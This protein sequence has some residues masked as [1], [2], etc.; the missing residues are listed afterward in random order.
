M[1]SKT[2]LLE[3]KIAIPYLYLHNRYKKHY[4]ILEN[5]KSLGVKISLDDYGVG[6]TSLG[7]LKSLP[8]D[9]LK[10]DKCF[11]LQLEQSKQDQY[12]VESTVNLGHQL[13]FSVVAE[14]VENKA[15]L[16]FLKLMKCDYAQGY[17][18][19]RPLKSEQFLQWLEV[20]N[21]AS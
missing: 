2:T 15:S 7:R 9:E 11:I 20:Y 19:S 10:L 12:I 16:D 8:I 13:G 14:G 21:E 17:Y 1:G 5:L 4:E 18:L 6:Q 3:Q